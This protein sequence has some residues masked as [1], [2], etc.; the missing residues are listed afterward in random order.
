[1]SSF[2]MAAAFSCL[3]RSGMLKTRQSPKLVRQ[4]RSTSVCL[5]VESGR[6]QEKYPNAMRLTL[7]PENKKTNA[8]R[9]QKQKTRRSPSC[10]VSL[11]LQYGFSDGSVKILN[12]SS[13]AMMTLC[14]CVVSGKGATPFS[15]SSG[16]GRGLLEPS[17]TAMAITGALC[18]SW[19]SLAS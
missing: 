9:H 12:C 6:R 5:V 15:T 1:M 16:S 14:A 8:T 3:L 17:N 13:E 11:Y 19:I 4:R 10:A 18:F 7:A 2:L